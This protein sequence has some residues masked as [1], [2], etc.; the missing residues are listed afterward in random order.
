VFR[1]AGPEEPSLPLRVFVF[2]S[3]A[4]FGTYHEGTL[5]EG[6]YR[7]GPERDFIV[8]RAGAT[9]GRAVYHEYV[10]RVLGRTAADFPLWFQEGSAELYSNVEAGKDRLTV[11][12]TDSRA[13]GDTRVGRVDEFGE[14][15]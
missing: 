15:R 8:L 12:R 5:V 4:E 14:A 11:G 1:E 2:A 9:A 7:N 3:R 13:S 6:F 10:H